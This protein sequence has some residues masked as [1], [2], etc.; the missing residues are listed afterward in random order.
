MYCNVK[1]KLELFKKKILITIFKVCRVSTN[2]LL[3]ISLIEMFSNHSD[4]FSHYII[5]KKILAKK[6]P[7]VIFLKKKPTFENIN[8][9]IF[10]TFWKDDCCTKFLFFELETSHFDNLLIF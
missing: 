3:K 1:K 4:F 5:E 8:R 7:L 2:Q 9:S 6:K 10:Q